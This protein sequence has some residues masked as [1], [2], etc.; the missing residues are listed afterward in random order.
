MHGSRQRRFFNGGERESLL[1]AQDGRCAICGAEL[2]PGFHVDHVL[3]VARGGKTEIGNAQAVCP[4]CNLAKSDLAP[5]GL[6]VWQEACLKKFLA[7]RGRDFLVSACPGAGKTRLA[8]AVIAEMMRTG[9]ASNLVIVVPTKSL[10]SD[11]G[12][13]LLDYYGVAVDANVASGKQFRVSMGGKKVRGCVVTYAGLKSISDRIRKLVT[14]N[15]LVV[16]DEPHHM[17]DEASWGDTVASVFDLAGKR[18]LLTGTPFRTDGVP[19]PYV[20]YDQDGYSVPDFDMSYGQALEAL[21]RIV[22]PV[23]FER[24]DGEVSW[25]DAQSLDVVTVRMSDRVPHHIARKRN[26]KAVQCAESNLWILDLF[27]R[28]ND[29]IS[30]CRAEGDTNAGGLAV[31]YTQ[32]SARK[33]VEMLTDGVSGL[34]LDANDVVLV[35]SDDSDDATADIKQFRD[36]NQRWIVAVHMVSEGVDI[37]RLRVGAFLT[38]VRTNLYFMQVVGRFIRWRSDLKCDQ[39]AYIFIPNDPEIIAFVEALE[40]M[41]G[42]AIRNREERG[43]IA[44][45]DD[46]DGDDQASE[47]WRTDALISAIAEYAGIIGTNGEGLP[48]RVLE[49]LAAWARDVGLSDVSLGEIC[50]LFLK[51]ASNETITI[52]GAAPALPVTTEGGASNWDEIMKQTDTLRDEL[53]RLHRMWANEVAKLLR[54]DRPDGRVYSHLWYAIKRGMGVEDLNQAD[55]SQLEVGLGVARSGIKASRR[56]EVPDGAAA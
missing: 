56:G 1:V 22:R 44:N 8:G 40:A 31:C 19:I 26:R 38:T 27:R 9:R 32:E 48:P 14:S 20:T 3:P 35:T 42:E 15:T 30:Q 17:A 53:N 16:F 2:E 4:A 43:E 25:L 21:P 51:L 7:H 12:R 54:Q 52:P 37:P 34:G 46:S 55:I 23:F 28:A 33:I 45:S 18:L 39:T 11:W 6:R 5:Y 10:R 29:R 41:R 13:V 47:R 36:G 50:R 24:M 49:Q